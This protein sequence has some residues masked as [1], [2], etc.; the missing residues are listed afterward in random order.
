MRFQS[1]SLI[2]CTLW[3]IG[4]ACIAD[5]FEDL[6]HK[7]INETGASLA[8]INQTVTFDQFLKGSIG[9]VQG[10]LAP[11]KD[12]NGTTNELGKTNTVVDWLRLGGTA[13]DVPFCRP[14]R[15]FHD[16]LQPWTSAGLSTSNPFINL[17]CGSSFASS[18]LWAQRHTQE[19]GAQRSWFEARSSYFDAL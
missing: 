1:G 3:F 7:L 12:S 6:T 10:S 18:V 5:A 17:I 11:L 9:L 19:V 16:P 13:E 14:A 4:S 15:H 8:R 2:A